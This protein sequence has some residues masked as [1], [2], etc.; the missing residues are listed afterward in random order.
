[1]YGEEEQY[2]YVYQIVPFAL[3]SLTTCMFFFCITKWVLAK[4]QH[5]EINK[6]TLKPYKY[7][8]ITLALQIVEMSFSCLIVTNETYRRDFFDRSVGV[9]YTVTNGLW[10]INYLCKIF[11]YTLFLRAV[12]FEQIVL[13]RFIN[14]Q[15]FLRLENLDVLRR[16]Y[17]L[18]EKAWSFHEKIF[19]YIV[20]SCL[21]I[22]IGLETAQYLV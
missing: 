5:L 19:I 22:C 9:A 16:T 12:I 7:T 18:K 20:A 14:F 2:D 1:M 6:L 8:A 3:T 17:N 11:A 13:Y 15:S 4:Y 21:L 10:Q